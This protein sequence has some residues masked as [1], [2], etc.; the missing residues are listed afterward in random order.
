MFWG[1]LI[2]GN[3]AKRTNSVSYTNNYCLT[4]ALYGLQDLSSNAIKRILPKQHSALG[5][6]PHFMFYI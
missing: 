3:R 6:K 5:L 2:T 1:S 4:V